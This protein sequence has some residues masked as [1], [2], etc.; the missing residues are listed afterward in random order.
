MDEA[1]FWRVVADVRDE[2]DGNPEVMAELLEFTLQSSDNETLR[3]FQSRLVAASNRLYTW[4]NWEAAEMIYGFMSEDAFTD[5]RSWVITLGQDWFE[6][7]AV[8]P[9]NLADVDDLSGGCEAG[10]ELFGAAVAN[11][12]FERQ[13]AD[14][15]EHDFPALEPLRPPSGQKITDPEEI[16]AALPRLAARI[17]ADGLGRA[18]RRFQGG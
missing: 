8:N 6:R 14:D 16:R 5:W 4:R 1:T 11:V 17:P 13:T 7:V 15:D 10:G 3:A 2:A 9:D 18:P 12:Y